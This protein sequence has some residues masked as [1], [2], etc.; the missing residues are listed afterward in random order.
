MSQ[1]GRSNTRW[2][3]ILVMAFWILSM[4]AAQAY[5]DPGSGSFVFQVV[6]GG[7]L[8]AGVTIKVFW[9]RFVQIVTRRGSTTHDD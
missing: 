6:V 3:A 9:K 8:A 4:P 5:V 7:I 2:G 1:R